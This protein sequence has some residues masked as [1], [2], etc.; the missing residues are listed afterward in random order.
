MAVNEN[1]EVKPQGKAQSQEFNSPVIN[2]EQDAMLG[3][4]QV[5]V[6]PKYIPSQDSI[7]K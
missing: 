2:Q 6:E 5:D 1:I 7:I 4:A 3:Q